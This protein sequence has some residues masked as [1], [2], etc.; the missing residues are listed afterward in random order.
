[1]LVALRTL[2]VMEGAVILEARGGLEEAVTVVAVA[3]TGG[4]LVI[5]EGEGG[6][7]GAVAVVARVHSERASK[8]SRFGVGRSVLC[9]SLA[10]S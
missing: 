7:E 8:P 5:F 2:V 10:N 6:K 9:F 3:V 1:M 4:E